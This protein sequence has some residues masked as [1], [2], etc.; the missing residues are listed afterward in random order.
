MYGDQSR[1]WPGLV[2]TLSRISRVIGKLA[3][4]VPLGGKES[5]K[6]VTMMKRGPIPYMHLDTFADMPSHIPISKTS[7]CFFV[8]KVS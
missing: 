6:Q 5:G 3:F 8:K 7:F 4:L 1:D 2:S